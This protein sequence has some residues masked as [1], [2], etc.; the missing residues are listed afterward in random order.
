MKIII[1]FALILSSYI[2]ADEIKQLLNNIKKAQPSQKRELINR[3]KLK[4]RHMNET[5]RLQ[6]I[7]KLQNM[8]H[9]RN[10]T[11]KY[12][13]TMQVHRQEDI[14]KQKDI[15]RQKGGKNH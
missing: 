13:T 3:L 1:I 11:H 5:H 9:S 8:Q 7:S 2:N 10:R 4:L 6:T 14:H 12:R 15:H